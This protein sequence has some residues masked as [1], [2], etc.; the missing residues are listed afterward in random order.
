MYGVIGVPR[1]VKSHSTY[2]PK[3]FENQDSFRLKQQHRVV[4]AMLMVFEDSFQPIGFQYLDVTVR[5]KVAWTSLR[6]ESQKRTVRSK[7]GVTVIHM[8]DS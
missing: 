2:E 4:R 8:V 5:W 6:H 7:H 3:R 1:L